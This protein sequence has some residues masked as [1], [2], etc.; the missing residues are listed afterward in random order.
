MRRNNQQQAESDRFR[1]E[2]TEISDISE[3][4]NARILERILSGSK[5]GYACR[6][7]VALSDIQRQ[8]HEAVQYRGSVEFAR[9]DVKTLPWLPQVLIEIERDIGIL[10]PEQ[11]R[12]VLLLLQQTTNQMVRAHFVLA[13]YLPLFVSPG[14][15]TD[16]H[17]QKGAITI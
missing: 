8:V 15:N 11:E 3:G 2:I 4:C 17:P 6:L 1:D 7:E 16:K 14:Y 9:S 10:S 12:P 13:G 5:T